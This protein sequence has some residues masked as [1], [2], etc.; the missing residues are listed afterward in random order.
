M[1]LTIVRLV[2]ASRR[3]VIRQSI[4][5]GFGIYYSTFFGDFSFG[6]NRGR[7]SEL[8]S[9][10]KLRLVFFSMCHITIVLDIK[11]VLTPQAT[12]VAV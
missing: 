4:A 2:H 5:S 9:S 1:V 10:S 3:V 12:V 6:I 11:E 7:I 8:L